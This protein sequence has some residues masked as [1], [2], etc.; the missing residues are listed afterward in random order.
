MADQVSNTN[1]TIGKTSIRYQNY[2]LL[3]SQYLPFYRPLSQN[4]SA[5]SVTPVHFP[6]RFFRLNIER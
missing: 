4:Q 1:K 3:I 6:S 2:S 5:Y